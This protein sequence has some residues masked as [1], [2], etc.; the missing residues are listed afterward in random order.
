MESLLHE[1]ESEEDAIFLERWKL[2]IVSIVLVLVQSNVD[3]IL[4][5]RPAAWFVK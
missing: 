1:L 5:L 4:H 3:S 2:R